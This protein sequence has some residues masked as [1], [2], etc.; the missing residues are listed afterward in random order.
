ML[1]LSD[2]VILL[3]G[4]GEIYQKLLQNYDIVSI[5]DLLMTFP[6]KR[7][8]ID[9]ISTPIGNNDTPIV[10]VDE[11]TRT[12]CNQQP[13]EIAINCKIEKVL[14]YA[15]HCILHC[16][17][18]H[19]QTI[20]T[21]IFNTKSIQ[22]LYPGREICICGNSD[23]SHT[24]NAITDK[25]TITDKIIIKNARIMPSSQQNIAIIK[26]GLDRIH[27]AAISKA[28][29]FAIS[30][31]DMHD[32]LIKCAQQYYD[33]NTQI[34]S[35]IPNLQ[36]ALNWIHNSFNTHHIERANRRFALNEAVLY[37]KSIDT[38][39][40]LYNM[41]DYVALI[42]NKDG[43][44][45]RSLTADGYIYLGCDMHLDFELTISQRAALDEIQADLQ[46]A[47]PMLRILY[48]DVGSGKSIVAFLSMIYASRSGKQA[49]LLVPTEILAQQH[50]QSI[51]KVYSAHA[52]V[53]LVS[54][55]M[56]KSK[57]D[58]II[59]PDNA[60]IIGTHALL[61]QVE[62]F[63][64]IGLLVIDEQ[65]KFGVLQRMLSITKA[66]HCLMMTAT[67]IPRTFEMAMRGILK[68]SQIASEFRQRTIH[69]SF[70]QMRNLQSIY[71]KIAK[72]LQQNKSIFWVCPLI[73]ISKYKDSG[74]VTHRYNDLSQQFG[75]CV[76]Y[77]HSKMSAQMK[78][79]IMYSFKS[80][81][82]M[83]LVSTTMIEV[84]VNIPHADIMVIENAELFG[85]A[86]LYQLMGRI[87]RG[88]DDGE[89]YFLL[90]N[91]SSQAR[92]RMTAIKHAQ[93]GLELANDD[94][95]IR[96]TGHIFGTKQSGFSGYR[97]IDI[98]K[99]ADLL[100]LAR[101]YINLDSA[102][103][104]SSLELLHGMQ[105]DAVLR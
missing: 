83:I 71:A 86:Q 26:Y 3:P 56:S 92:E 1:R 64:N 48:G 54:A 24:P 23:N 19:N 94:A 55:G 13:T 36:D 70:V 65:H 45:I 2:K 97:F 6:K 91:M 105:T 38:L 11:Q 10:S 29:N 7:Y 68:Q 14:K 95:N 58:R 77:L 27:D 81:P 73:D 44:D 67:P 74:N 103:D 15:K 57:K 69:K 41:H 52:N 5:A 80:K 49:L 40:N 59:Y 9:V 25:I 53:F 16:K 76:V 96:G 39:K 42:H 99:D 35:D 62:K 28:I 75:E 33:H 72:V 51:L 66:Y 88:Y 61:Y 37:M 31:I 4:I 63:P 84:G 50:Y 32:P 22:F 12:S 89:C 20:Q 104:V 17:N 90:G 8:Y 21:T 93:S 85:L 18:A 30:H 87:G 79:E 82:G 47:R 78:D 34:I 46:S 98:H 43:H 101:A 102:L 100:D 60:I